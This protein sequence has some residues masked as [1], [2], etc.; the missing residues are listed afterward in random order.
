M[1]LAVIAVALL[2]WW[3]HRDGLL[4]PNIIRLGGA[5]GAALLT[6]RL[7]STGR[8]MAGG[9]VAAIG[10]GWWLWHARERRDDGLMQAARLLKVAP[11]AQSETVWQAWRQAMTRAHPDAGGSEAEAKALTAA[12]DLLIAAAEQR[13][14]TGDGNGSGGSGGGGP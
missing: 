13:R 8:V 4:I 10:I 7:L 5:A 14:E 1:A 9:A 11:D 3:L 6:F 2:A 12:R